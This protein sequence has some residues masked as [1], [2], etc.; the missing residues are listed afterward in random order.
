[1]VGSLALFMD[2]VEDKV[3]IML[4][5]ENIVQEIDQFIQQNVVSI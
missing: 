5:L 4:E 1:M 3:D 2:P